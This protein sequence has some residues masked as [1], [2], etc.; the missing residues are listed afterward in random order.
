VSAETAI[1]V[2]ASIIL[3]VFWFV[4][5]QC[6][7]HQPSHSTADK[8]HGSARAWDVANVLQVGGI[9][10][11]FSAVGRIPDT[12]PLQSAGLATMMLGILFRWHAMRTLGRLFTGKVMIRDGH[13]LIRVGPYAHLRH[14]AY[15][16]S[17]IAHI[18]LG[19]ALANWWALAASTLPYLVAVIYRIR[20]EEKVLAAAFG[21]EY[22]EHA[23]ATRRLVPWIY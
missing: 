7:Q 10:V 1:R 16:G 13:H 12:A 22:D 4:D 23:R 20:V 3:A 18:G 6:L 5:R 11:S 19:L 2:A 21:A 17:L 8:D 14:P 15:T 9:V